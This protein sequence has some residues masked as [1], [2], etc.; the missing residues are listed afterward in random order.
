MFLTILKPRVIKKFT[1]NYIVFHLVA[2]HEKFF[3]LGLLFI[4]GLFDANLQHL[5]LE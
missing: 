3:F 1:E 5:S 4:Y 2:F